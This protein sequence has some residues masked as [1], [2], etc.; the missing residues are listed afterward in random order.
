V[1][2]ETYYFKCFLKLIKDDSYC[3]WST[4][5]SLASFGEGRIE[6]AGCIGTPVQYAVHGS[7]SKPDLDPFS[8]F[9]RTRACY[10]QTDTL[11][12]LAVR[13]RIE[14]KLAVLVYKSLN[15]LSARY[16]MDDC[17]HIT[18][19]GRRRLRSPNVATCDVPR[20]RTSPGYRSFTAAGP[21][22]YICGI[23]D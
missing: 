18:T 9:C 15:G 5:S 13:Q 12:W 14:L 7:P 16:L 20:T 1:N 3:R 19:T 11:H 21:R 8:L 2:F 23:L 22:Q 6:S 10:R 4:K 17:Q